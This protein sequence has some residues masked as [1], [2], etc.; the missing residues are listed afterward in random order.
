MCNLTQSSHRRSCPKRK[1]HKEFP[2]HDEYENRNKTDN[3]IRNSDLISFLNCSHRL[4]SKKK[5]KEKKAANCITYVFSH[6]LLNSP[7]VLLSTTRSSTK[8]GGLQRPAITQASN[9]PSLEPPYFLT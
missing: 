7:P 6:D 3:T 2:S 1:T 9:L 4:V 5:R 8:Q